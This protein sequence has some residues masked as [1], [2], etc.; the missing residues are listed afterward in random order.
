MNYDHH[1]DR[2]YSLLTAHQPLSGCHRR[3]QAERDATPKYSIIRGN[4]TLLALGA[5]KLSFSTPVGKSD[6]F[7][8]DQSVILF[9]AGPWQDYWAEDAAV[10]REVAAR[11]SSR[12]ISPVAL[13][14]HENK[15]S[16]NII[17]IDTTNYN[18]DPVALVKSYKSN[19]R[20]AKN[21]R[22]A[23]RIC[24]NCP[25]KARCDAWDVSMGQTADWGAG[26]RGTY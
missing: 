3:T 21:T 5:K 8:L 26:Y 20:I 1:I 15:G 7:Q 22:R 13:I 24:P 4:A 10:E 2:L 18:I 23:Q 17:E 14:A 6:S 12:Q 19:G 11:Y 9:R 16:L 25:I